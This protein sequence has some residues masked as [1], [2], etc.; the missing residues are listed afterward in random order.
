[1]IDRQ[2]IMIIMNI[3]YRKENEITNFREICV[4]NI[5]KGI[6]YRGSYPVF[7]LD[8]KRDKISLVSKI[9]KN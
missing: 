9:N 8:K 5:K 7:K 2:R 3:T 4:G 6:L 1:M